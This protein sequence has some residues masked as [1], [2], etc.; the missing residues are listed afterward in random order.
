MAIVK[1]VRYR[2]A[3][4]FAMGAAFALSACGG[5]PPPA[6]A[7]GPSETKPVAASSPAEVEKPLNEPEGVIATLRWKSP[8]E[9]VLSLA[10]A[11][12][13]PT[14][15][16]N[17]GVKGLL[18]VASKEALGGSGN[19]LSDLIATDAP[20]DILTVLPAEG[21]KP[22]PGVI[23]SIGLTSFERA[24]SLASKAH[25]AKVTDIG[26]GMARL[27]MNQEDRCVLAEAKGKAPARIICSMEEG[28]SRLSEFAGYVARDLPIQPSKDAD[29]RGELRMG[30]LDH[31]FGL[32]K[33]VAS[34]PLTMLAAAV[35]NKALSN[36]LMDTADALRAEASALLNDVTLVGFDI[37]ADSAKG[38]TLSL[39]LDSKSTTSW[40]LSTAADLQSKS[41][42]P[43]AAF[44]HLPKDASSATYSAVVPSERIDAMRKSV[45]ALVDG[46]LDYAKVPAADRKAIA[47]IFERSYPATF[48]VYASGVSETA[49]AKDVPAFA[50]TLMGWHIGATDQNYANAVAGWKEIVAA[51]NRPAL[52]SS[53]KKALK[54]K[55]VYVPTLK[56]GT[57]P[58][59]LGKD[60]FAIEITLIL[61]AERTAAPP[62][63][64]TRKT[65]VPSVATG[66]NA[67]AKT[68]K[69]ALALYFMNDGG[70]TWYGFSADKKNLLSHLT[71]AK[72]TTATAETLATRADLEPLKSVK[73]IGGGFST[74]APIIRAATQAGGA[75]PYAGIIQN[76]VRAL[77]HRGDGAMFHH[78]D[79]VNGRLSFVF[80]MPKAPL[81]DV[82]SVVTGLAALAQ[83][84]GG[85]P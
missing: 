21:E 2:S 4:L 34:F 62:P 20:I 45:A 16:A 23:V 36:A 25:G 56:A 12:G 9:T 69:L 82:G 57:A 13:V 15:M 54:E 59:E 39:N 68:T 72:S 6:A 18:R 31:R 7:T 52:Q 58:K 73:W 81:E 71:V 14:D 67:P 48:S 8:M 43:P 66:K 77:P 22:T 79:F 76:T 33:T 30:A 19:E 70:L 3:F 44:W 42:P 51:Y 5:A 84:F 37:K 26:R 38:L 17:D 1:R 53:L 24:K 83:A 65:A 60:A 75:S 80:Q 78:V 55:A 40:F 61:P 74:L 63:A 27:T 50:S 29:I 85:N 28:H 49:P 11:A 32:K 10:T 46:G 47:H 64:N 41:G 35:D